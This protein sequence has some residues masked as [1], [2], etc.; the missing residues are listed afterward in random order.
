MEKC[1]LLGGRTQLPSGNGVWFLTF[2]GGCLVL[3][4]FVF[5]PSSSSMQD[6]E[7]AWSKQFHL[8]KQ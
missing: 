8:G 5:L 7:Q 2:G 6:M 4:C 1:A 3:S